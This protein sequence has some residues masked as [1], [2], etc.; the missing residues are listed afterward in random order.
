MR[1]ERDTQNWS[2]LSRTLR[3]ELRERLDRDEQVVILQNRRGFS[4]VVQCRG[5]DCGK[6]VECRNCKVTMTYHQSDERLKC[7][8]CGDTQRIPAACPDCGEQGL[9]YGGSGTQKVQDEITRAFPDTPLI[10]MDQDTT[11]LKGAHHRLLEQFRQRNASILLGTQMVSKGLDFP[12]VTLVGVISADIGLWMPDFRAAE[13]TFQLLTQVAGRTGRGSQ[14]G[15]VVIQTYQP[16]HPVVQAARNHDVA[17][18]ARAELAERE[19][20]GNPPFGKLV[21]CLL[22][23]TD[24]DK[25]I[26][27]AEQIGN[28]ARRLAPANVEVL[29]PTEAPLARIK[30]HWRQHVLLKGASGG[31][32]RTV[33]R[34][35]KLRYVKLPHA[36]NVHLAVD[37]DPMTLL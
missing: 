28:I 23:G 34:E 19:E 6:A 18:F 16:E 17:T 26:A 22:K 37:V 25:T 29:G 2:S 20:L 21:Q 30:N 24:Q 8:Y 27:A 1:H 14:P 35:L 13:R 33:A 9:K 36:R 11:R 10:R 12:D 3:A 32:L 5:P 31:S 7:H 4:P 15:E